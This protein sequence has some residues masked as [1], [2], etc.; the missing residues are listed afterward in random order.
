MGTAPILRVSH[1]GR[2]YG[3]GKA[4]GVALDDITLS[5]F[6][7]GLVCVLG[8]SGCGKT[9]L[10]NVLGGMDTTFTGELFIEETAASSNH[11]SGTTIAPSV[12]ASSFR[13]PL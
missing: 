13:I 3:T 2:H 5:L 7:P 10:L 6:S 8:P 11:R 1:L 4:A 9:T 12:S